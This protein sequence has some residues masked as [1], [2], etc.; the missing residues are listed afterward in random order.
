MYTSF[1]IRSWILFTVAILSW[2]GVFFFIFTLLG[3]QSERAQYASDAA[4]ANLQQGQAAQ[5]RVLA[6]ETEEDRRTLASVS[7]VDLLSAINLIESVDASGTP[8]QVTSAQA[9][10]AVPAKNAA[11]QINVVDLTAHA[12]GTFSSLVHIMETLE[13]LPLATT[14]QQVDLTRGAVDPNAKNAQTPWQLNVKLRFY[15]TATIS[16]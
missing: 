11:L 12:E 1:I 15:T 3:M 16:T 7:N 6:R 14:V 5:L 13:T 9:A 10:K 2:C 8:V 4:A